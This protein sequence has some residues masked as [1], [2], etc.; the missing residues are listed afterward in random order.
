MVRKMRSAKVLIV[1]L[2]FLAYSGQSA[3]REV[4]RLQFEDPRGTARTGPSIATQA[5]F[6][7][8]NHVSQ[9]L[10]EQFQFTAGSRSFAPSVAIESLTISHGCDAAN[11]RPTWWLPHATEKRRASYHGILTDIACQRGLPT[12]LLDAV[13]A[14]ESGFASGSISR[15]G[16]MGMMQ[17]MPGTARSLGLRNPFDPIAN[18]RAGARYLGFS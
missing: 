2:C 15:A 5:E 10:L 3:A 16:A 9:S 13:I 1:A 4:E 7:P 14:Q 6:E 8:S 18:M 17:I 11:Y 12:R